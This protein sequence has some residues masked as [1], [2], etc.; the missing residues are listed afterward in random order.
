MP[1]DRP[2]QFTITLN[3]VLALGGFAESSSLA[4]D[5]LS[6]TPAG[7][8]KGFHITLKRG[9][10]DSVLFARWLE[11]CRKAGS[12]VRWSAVIAVR[13]E[14]G[15]LVRSWKLRSV[16]PVKYSGP[17]LNAGGGEVAMEELTLSAE[18]IEPA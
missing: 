3:S 7:F 16:V 12:G 8:G 14:R 13:N 15:S 1:A 2:Y 11:E 9:I 6:A 18:G 5:T 17:A 10:V 4:G